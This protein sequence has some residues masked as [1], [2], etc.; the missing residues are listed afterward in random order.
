MMH[1]QNVI[2]IFFSFFAI[3]TFLTF[4]ITLLYKKKPTLYWL[5]L[6]GLIKILN[7]FKY[8]TIYTTQQYFSLSSSLFFNDIF[9]SKSPTNNPIIIK[10]IGATLIKLTLKNA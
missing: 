10:Y 2:F 5:F 7:I 1:Y 3:L 4:G 8:K 9:S 6:Y